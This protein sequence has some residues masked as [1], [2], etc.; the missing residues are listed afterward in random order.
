MRSV[1]RPCSYL[2]FQFIPKVNDG[3]EF[4]A[5]YGPVKFFHTKLIHPCL[6]GPLLC[7]VSNEYANE[8]TTSQV[9]LK[10]NY[11]TGALYHLTRQGYLLN[12]WLSGPSSSTL[13]LE[14]TTD[15]MKHAQWQSYWMSRHRNKHP[16]NSICSSWSDGSYSVLAS[17]ERKWRQPYLQGSI[18]GGAPAFTSSV[19]GAGAVTARSL[20]GVSALTCSLS[21]PVLSAAAST[22]IMPTVFRHQAA[23]TV[24]MFSPSSEWLTCNSVSGGKKAVIKIEEPSIASSSFSVVLSDGC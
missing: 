7:N 23:R 20:P 4:R 24:Q 2:L 21:G 13:L 3:V 11:K 8:F 16:T 15:H 9:H 5:L 12:E 1:T 17:W 18:D 19:W 6:Y 14:M 10:L 22:T